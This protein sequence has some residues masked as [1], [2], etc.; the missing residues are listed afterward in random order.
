MPF[1]K[2]DLCF[3]TVYDIPHVGNIRSAVVYDVI[4]RVFKRFFADVIYVRNITDVDDKI[5]QA[6]ESQGKSTKEIAT[7]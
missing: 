7:F 2:S 4:F 3:P 6:A 5:I 1:E